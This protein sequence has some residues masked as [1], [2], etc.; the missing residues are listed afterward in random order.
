MDDGL[1]LARDAARLGVEAIVV[2]T[3]SGGEAMSIRVARIV[4]VAMDIVGAMA[5][6]AAFTVAMAVVVA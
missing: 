3:N 2:V 4:A 6:A 5:I 1:G